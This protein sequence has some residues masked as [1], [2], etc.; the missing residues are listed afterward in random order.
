MITVSSLNNFED[1]KKFRSCDIFD[2]IQRSK[3]VRE[4]LSEH[5]I[6]DLQDKFLNNG[7]HYIAVSSV[8]FGRLLISRFL[9]SLNCYHENAILTI[10]NPIGNNTIIDLYYELL[11]GGYLSGNKDLDDFFIDQ[12][13][14]DFI[15]IEACHELVDQKWFSEFF[16]KLLSFKID[17]H[18][19]VLVISYC[20]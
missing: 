12:F 7:F 9:R 11:Q 4:P 1:K 14:Y 10:S 20:K 17:R 16:S 13:Y 5:D 3:H 8:S 15:W 2:H 19:P 6:L 18:I